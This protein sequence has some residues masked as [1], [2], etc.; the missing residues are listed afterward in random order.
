MNQLFQQINQ[1]SRKPSSINDNKIKFLKQ[2]FQEYKFA[3]N[4]V[5]YMNGMIQSNP[6]VRQ[7]MNMAQ[8]NGG[9]MKQLFYELAESKGVDPNS[10]LELFK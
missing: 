6:Q 3:S 7:V 9:D 1:S 10:I 8:Q 2:K 5:A 4:P